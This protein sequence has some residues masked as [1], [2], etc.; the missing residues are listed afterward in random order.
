KNI[1]HLVEVTMGRMYVL[2]AWVE[3]QTFKSLKELG[4]DTTQPGTY[5]ITGVYMESAGKEPDEKGR[6]AWGGELFTNTVRVE[7]AAQ[8]AGGRLQ[9]L[10]PPA[11]ARRSSDK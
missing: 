1:P 5:Q 3:G 7:V 9:E 2:P 6:M 11:A 4:L 8:T 10:S